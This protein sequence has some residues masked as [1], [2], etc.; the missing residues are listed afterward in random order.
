MHRV[1]I[2][3]LILAG[4]LSFGMVVGLAQTNAL[5]PKSDPSDDAASDQGAP[6]YGPMMGW[7]GPGGRAM[8]GM[9]GMSMGRGMGP[10]MMGGGGPGMCAAMAAHVEGRL[11]YLKVELKITEAQDQPW[12]AYAAAVRDSAQGMQARCTTMMDAHGSGGV[13]LPDRMDLHA[14]FMEAQLESLK[15][16]TKALKPLYDALNAEQKKV[17]DQM[18]WGMGMM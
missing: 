15:A 14:A 10:W 1:A 11:A 17:A 4:C 2:S 13:S 5:A 12:K 3:T 9:G 8:T 6:Q 16:T 18:S 7:W